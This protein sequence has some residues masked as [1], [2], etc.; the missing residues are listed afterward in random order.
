M[1]R[2]DTLG[3][4]VNTPKSVFTVQEIE[5]WGYQITAQNSRPLTERVQSIRKYKRPANIQVLR[6]FF[7]ILNFY[8]R[9]LKDAAK[10]QVL[11]HEYLKGTKKKDKIK[12]QRTQDAQKQFHNFQNDLANASLLSLPDSELTLSLFTDA[13]DT[14]IGSV[15]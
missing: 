2:L 1:E 6:I 15:L 4:I 14:E 12:V 10:K 8:H 11:L 3:I 5:F 9:Y 7:G 13:S